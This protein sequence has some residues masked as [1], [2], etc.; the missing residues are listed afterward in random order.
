MTR[1]IERDRSVVPA[2]DVPL[3]VFRDIVAATADIDAVGGYKVG[4]ALMGRPGYDAVVAAAREHTDKPLIFDPQKWGTDIPATAKT[5]MGP[6]KE[7]G[8]D[9]II[10]FPQAGPVTQYEWIRAA[11]EIDLPVIIGGEMTHP[12]YLEGDISNGNSGINYTEILRGLGIRFLATGYITRRAPSDIYEIAARMG[13]TNFVFPGNK[14]SQITKY[15]ERLDDLGFPELTVWS[16]G[17]VAQGGELSKG[18]E[19]AGPRFHA[20]V[21]RG[22]YQN[23]AEGRFNT[24]EEMRAAALTLTSKL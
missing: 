4:L 24:R 7:A 12:R 9:A 10:L 14:P 17:L 15:R 23:K 21:G 3:E 13:I 11:Q 18:A 6:V 2:C 16:P 1:I 20:I 19:A 22:I 8:I 5:M